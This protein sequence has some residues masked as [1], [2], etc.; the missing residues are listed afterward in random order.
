VGALPETS[1]LAVYISFGIFNFMV[2]HPPQKGEKPVRWV[3][4]SKSDFLEF[5]D[6]VISDMGHAL[7]V[8]QL[9]GKHP[10]AKLWKGEG[11]GVCE[12]VERFEGNAYRALYTVRFEGF[13]Y[14]L[15][16]FQKKS[17]TGIRTA[18]TDIDLV[19]ERLNRAREHFECNH[20]PSPKGKAGKHGR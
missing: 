5:P 8:A 2:R 4:S 17:P 16:A 11:S 7:G 12:L 15:H 13:V 20:Q 9:G 18:Q 10:A 19:R 3:G 14:V 1:T 6:G